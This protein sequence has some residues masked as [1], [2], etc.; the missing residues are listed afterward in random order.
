MFRSA[1]GHLVCVSMLTWVKPG[2]NQ[3]AILAIQGLSMK[4]SKSWSF[5]VTLYIV[6]L[7]VRHPKKR[8][9]TGEPPASRLKDRGARR[10]GLLLG[11]VACAMLSWIRHVCEHAAGTISL[12]LQQG[13]RLTSLTLNNP[14]AKTLRPKPKPTTS[15]RSLNK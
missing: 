10:A 14:K 12:L 7:L 15:C 1:S 11:N 5:W 8:P 9:E 13:P 6:L 2:P 4:P 3:D